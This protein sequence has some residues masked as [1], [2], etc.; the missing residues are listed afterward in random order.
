MLAEHFPNARLQLLGEGETMDEIRQYAAQ[1]ELEDRI[2]FEGSQSNVYPYLHE[3]D[4][5][6]LP[7]DYEG[8]PMTIIEAMGT[9]LP[10]VATAV[11]GVPDMVQDGIR[12]KGESE[13]GTVTDH[14]TDDTIGGTENGNATDS[15]ADPDNDTNADSGIAN[16]DIAG[17]GA[18][19]NGTEESSSGVIGWVIAV[20]VV[21]GIVLVVLALLPK[22]NRDRG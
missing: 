16:D 8:M 9:G 22:K 12:D 20:L 18:V 11:G 14:A 21:L 1:L 17:D 15:P 2:C 7:S 3:A 19:E 6:L 5:F 10:I 4:M 13:N